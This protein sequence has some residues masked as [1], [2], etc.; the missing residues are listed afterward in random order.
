MNE[1]LVIEYIPNDECG[2][3][4]IVNGQ[5]IMECISYEEFKRITI[6]KLVEMH[7]EMI[8]VIEQ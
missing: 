2:S 5:V 4:V 7:S 6:E 3:E 1:K 8:K